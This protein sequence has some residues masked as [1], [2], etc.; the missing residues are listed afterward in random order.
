MVVDTVQVENSTSRP[1]TLILEPYG[2]SVEMVPGVRYLVAGEQYADYPI[3]V[4]VSD[5]YIQVWVEGWSAA[6]QDGA[7]LDSTGYV[8]AMREKQEK[9]ARG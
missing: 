9:E 2:D 6:F 8:F 3:H 1:L 4:E 7:S 5:D